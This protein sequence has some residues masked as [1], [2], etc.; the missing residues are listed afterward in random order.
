M[1]VLMVR[2]THALTALG[3]DKIGLRFNEAFIYRSTA[4]LFKELVLFCSQSTCFSVSPRL[5]Q[6]SHRARKQTDPDCCPN[7]SA[8]PSAFGWGYLLF[9][10]QD[11]RCPNEGA[12]L[13]GCG[14]SEMELWALMTVDR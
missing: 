12:Q 7:T 9:R 1:S 14:Q 6:T 2:R 13:C 4:G 10:Q 3:D 5:R 8:G 11:P